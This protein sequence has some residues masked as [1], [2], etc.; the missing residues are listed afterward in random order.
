[1]RCK[2]NCRYCNAIPINSNLKRL[3]DGVYYICID[4]VYKCYAV[5]FEK[6]NYFISE[7]S[8]NAYIKWHD[9]MDLEF[10][11]K[12][13]KWYKTFEEAKTQLLITKENTFQDEMNYKVKCHYQDM[14]ELSELKEE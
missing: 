12:N 8:Y 11:S 1:M 6:E 9:Q 13:C 10:Y 14:R 2:P 7:R 4:T 3:N 5:N